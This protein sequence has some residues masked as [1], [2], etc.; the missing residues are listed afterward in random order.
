M[1][2]ELKSRYKSYFIFFHICSTG[3]LIF[4]NVFKI[5]NKKIILALSAER[6]FLMSFNNGINILYQSY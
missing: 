5:G 6:E 2:Q 1:C 4:Y 3:V